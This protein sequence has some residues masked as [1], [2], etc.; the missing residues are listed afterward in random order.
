MSDSQRAETAQ[1]LFAPAIT[2]E[3]I[4]DALKLENERRA[5]LVKNMY[6]LRALRLSRGNRSV[7]ER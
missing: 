1:T 2:R 3:E 6:R 7:Q 4:A 5:V